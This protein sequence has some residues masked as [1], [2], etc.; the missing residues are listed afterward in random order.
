M[1]ILLCGYPPFYSNHGLPISPGMKKR[2]R[3]GQYDFPDPEWKHVSRDGKINQIILINK[4]QLI[5]IYIFIY[6]KGSYQRITENWSNTEINYWKCHET[7][8]DCSKLF[9][10]G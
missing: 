1:Y 4:T 10:N 9:F 2:I 3:A 7:Q 5:F 6:S 8:L